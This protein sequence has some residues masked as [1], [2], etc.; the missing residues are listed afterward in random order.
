V[1]YKEE[2]ERI[3]YMLMDTDV[4]HLAI[5]VNNALNYLDELRAREDQK[6]KEEQKIDW[7]KSSM[8]VNQNGNPL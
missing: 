4:S 5:R 3:A 7:L 8:A 1:T 2:L 6:E